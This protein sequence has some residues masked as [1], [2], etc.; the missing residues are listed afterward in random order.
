MNMNQL[1][2]MIIV[3]LMLTSA[4][5]DVLELMERKESP[6]HREKLVNKDPKGSKEKQVLLVL[7]DKMVLMEWMLTN[8]VLPN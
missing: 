5:A 7:M 4:L 1:K 8:H 3:L 2:P 6:D